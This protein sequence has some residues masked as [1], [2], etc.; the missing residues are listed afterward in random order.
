MTIVDCSDS[1]LGGAGAQLAMR[2]TN[3][4]E[5]TVRRHMMLL[6]MAIGR[7]VRWV[8]IIGSSF[9]TIGKRRFAERLGPRVGDARRCGAP[10]SRA[11]LIGAS[12][13]GGNRTKG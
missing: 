5:P 13:G 6:G 2:P 9:E 10:S 3:A 11:S 12:R 7:R 8:F 4:S 1:S